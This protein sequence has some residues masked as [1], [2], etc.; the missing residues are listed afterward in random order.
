[1]PYAELE[2]VQSRIPTQLC[3]LGPA[4]QPSQTDVEAWLA[5]ISNWV[6]SG[7]AWKYE[8]PITA[9]ADLAVLKPIVADLV[10]ARVWSV[11]AGH[12]EEY[13]KIGESLARNARDMLMFNRTTGRMLLVLPSTTLATEGEAAVAQPAGTF[14]N[15]DVR[16]NNP[17]LFKIGMNF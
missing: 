17:R 5:Q 14:T 3:E 11:L 9:E 15:P 4:S 16:G 6:D 1:M 7:F 10:A 13:G 8:I 2:D 12:S